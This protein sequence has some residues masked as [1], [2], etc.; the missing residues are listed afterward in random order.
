MEGQVQPER[1]IERT[2]LN[3]LADASRDGLSEMVLC[4]TIRH[5]APDELGPLMNSD[6]VKALKRLQ[7]HGRVTHSAGRWRRLR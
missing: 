6:V 7:A 5:R 2:C 1:W 3:R 4:A